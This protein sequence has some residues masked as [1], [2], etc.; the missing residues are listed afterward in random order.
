MIKGKKFSQV[1]VGLADTGFRSTFEISYNREL[2]KYKDKILIFLSPVFVLVTIMRYSHNS[3]TFTHIVISN[4]ITKN[5]LYCF[6]NTP[7]RHFYCIAPPLNLYFI[8]SKLRF[9]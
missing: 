3:Y 2:M 9:I 6:M 1:R 7:K 4:K 8:Y 5:I